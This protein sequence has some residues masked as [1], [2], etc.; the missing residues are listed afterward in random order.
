MIEANDAV[1]NLKHFRG[2]AWDVGSQSRPSVRAENRA[3]HIIEAGLPDVQYLTLEQHRL[4]ERSSR[5]DA[6]A[7]CSNVVTF[8]MSRLKERLKYTQEALW[9]IGKRTMRARISES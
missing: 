9:G 2:I 5:R 6:V 4:G 3:R 7:R 1:M 8:D